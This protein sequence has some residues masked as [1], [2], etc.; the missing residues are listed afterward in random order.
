LPG[1]ESLGP[2]DGKILKASAILNI[3]V[4]DVGMTDLT[5]S[6]SRLLESLS[7]ES[8]R[9]SDRNFLEDYNNR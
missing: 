3:K 5:L 1:T 2:L 8:R 4:D 9:G 6:S 7:L